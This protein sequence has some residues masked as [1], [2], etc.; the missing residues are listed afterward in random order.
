M[1]TVALIRGH[2]Y[3]RTSST[4]F[5]SGTRSSICPSDTTLMWLQTEDDLAV[6]E[7]FTNNN[8]NGLIFNNLYYS[9]T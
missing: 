2:Y 8:N 7:H 6:F 5:D 1:D 9:Q 4:N 3:V